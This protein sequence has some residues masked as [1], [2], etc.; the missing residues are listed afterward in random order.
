MRISD[1]SSDVCS[2]DLHAERKVET[3]DE[4][5]NANHNPDRNQDKR[6]QRTDLATPECAHQNQR[7]NTDHQSHG[8]TEQPDGHHRAPD[9]PQAAH[10]PPPPRFRSTPAPDPQRLVPGTSVPAPSPPAGPPT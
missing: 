10:L 9:H 4:Q 1:W 8:T 6:L 5:D 2:S 3:V 7:G